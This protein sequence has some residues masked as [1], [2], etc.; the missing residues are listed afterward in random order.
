VGFVTKIT[1]MLATDFCHAREAGM[2]DLAR[3]P[4]LFR[5][6]CRAARL[7]APVQ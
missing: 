6:A 7:F 4:F 3:K 2:E 5:A 1:E